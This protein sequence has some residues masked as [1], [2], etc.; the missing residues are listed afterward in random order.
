[1]DPNLR[2]G[3]TDV[4]LAEDLDRH[5]LENGQAQA[6]AELLVQ[7]LADSSVSEGA[8]LLLVGA[9]TGQFLDFVDIEALVPFRLTCTDINARFLEAL[10]A[11]LERAPRLAADVLLDDIEETALQGPFDAAVAILVLEHIDWKKGVSSLVRLSPTWLHFIIQRN[12][13]ISQM[14]TATREL[15]PSIREF[16]R[17]ATPTLISEPELTAALGEAIYAPHRR[18]ERPVPDGKRMVGL[19]YRR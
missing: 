18:Y 19:V 17:I 2:K 14:L 10:R 8:S 4:V 3:W 1:M 11:R 16:G 6:N 5:L 7:M 9:G 13:A 12:E 15:A